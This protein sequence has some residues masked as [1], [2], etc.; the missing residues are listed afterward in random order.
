MRRVFAATAAAC[1]L[2]T[3]PVAADDGD[4]ARIRAGPIDATPM[5]P[6]VAERLEEIRRRIQEAVEYPELARRRGLEGVARVGF[7]I[8]RDNGLAREIRLVTSSGHP[9]LDRAAERSVTAAG[10]LPWVYGLLE[11]PVRFELAQRR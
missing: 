3:L 4:G 10:S 1:I 8:D 2:V 5:G 7:E 9:S 6:T 11:V